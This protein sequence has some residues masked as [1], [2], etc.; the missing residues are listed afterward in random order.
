MVEYKCK[1]CGEGVNLSD[2]FCPQCGFEHHILPEPISVEVK[3]YE[4]NRIEVCKK[5]WEE[6]NQGLKLRKTY[7]EVL[8][9][10]NTLEQELEKARKKI[11]STEEEKERYKVQIDKAQ[12]ELASVKKEKQ[13]L[14]DKVQSLS[15]QN[16]TLKKQISMLESAAKVVEAQRKDLFEKLKKANDNLTI[17]INEHKETKL[18]LEQLEANNPINVTQEQE[19]PQAQPQSYP[20]VNQQQGQPVAKIVFSCGI[21]TIQKNVFDGNNNYMIPSSM[22]S[23]VYGDAFRIESLDG[24]VFRLYDICGLTCKVNGDK[25]STT[26]MQLYDKDYFS[27][28]HITIQI[29]LPKMN[30]RDLIK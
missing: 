24:K 11:Q 22:N 8:S 27:V 10:K 30:L 14:V 7:D 3:M 13:G 23:S 21:Q 4:E 15:S 28:G 26:G 18:K 12:K 20:C 16:E 25:I 1:I 29:K 6:R 9:E 17:E 5:V 19:Q 2:S